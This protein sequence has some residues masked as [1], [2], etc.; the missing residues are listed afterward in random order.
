MIDDGS[1]NINNIFVLKEHPNLLSNLQLNKVFCNSQVELDF[2]EK[3]ISVVST[4][5]SQ[6]EDLEMST[7]DKLS[8]SSPIKSPYTVNSEWTECN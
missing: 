6:S 4:G 8:E 2:L 3:S 1:G 7:H 5:S